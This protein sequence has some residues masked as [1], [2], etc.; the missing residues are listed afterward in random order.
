M[1]AD[2]TV[3]EEEEEDPSDGKLDYA[4]DEVNATC[5][6]LL[7]RY[8][9]QR[10]YFSYV[11]CKASSPLQNYEYSRFLS[12]IYAQLLWS[13]IKISPNLKS[14]HQIKLSFSES[15]ADPNQVIQMIDP[16]QVF[17]CQIVT[18][19]NEDLLSCHDVVS[20]EDARDKSES[21]MFE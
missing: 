3:Q 2:T 4:S 18:V 14:K 13:I 20:C 21:R 11:P 6:I 15:T 17:T 19:V 9:Q 5:R 8:C 12:D 1:C 10:S 16:K 7:R